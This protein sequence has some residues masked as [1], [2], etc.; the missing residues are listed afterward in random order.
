[1]NNRPCIK[2]IKFWHQTKG[3]ATVEFALVAGLL[4]LLV[5]GILDFGHAWFMRQSIVNASREG[6]RYAV[7]YRVDANGNH[8]APENF[9]PSVKQF[10]ETLLSQMLPSGTVYSATPSG[11]GYHNGTSGREVTVT[12]TA[13]KTW[14]AVQNIV[15]LFGGDLGGDD[16]TL[17]ATTTMR[18]E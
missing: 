4:F 8:L 10:T 2:K 9:V 6:A 7:V 1:M 5:M 12:V 18:C 13:T 15:K 3:T 11:D 16:I 17:T 14:F